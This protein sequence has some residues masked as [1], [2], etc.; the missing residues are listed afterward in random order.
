MTS[1]LVRARPIMYQF[2]IRQV[3]HYD[4]R[5]ARQ[6]AR[7][8][9]RLSCHAVR[10]IP[11]IAS[12]PPI[13]VSVMGLNFPNP[14]GLAAGFDKNGSLTGSLGPAGFGFVEIG[15]ITPDRPTKRN[16]GIA[17]MISNLKRTRSRRLSGPGQLLGVNVGSVRTTFSEELIDD[18]ISAMEVVWDQADYLTI[19]LSSPHGWAHAAGVSELEVQ[20]LLERIKDRHD[21][22][23]ARSGQRLPIT[24]KVAVTGDPIHPAVHIARD[25]GFDALTV[26]T[27]RADPSNLVCSQI[28]ELA[29]TLSPT[30]LIS[31]GGITSVD[32]AWRRLEAGAALVQLYTG[33][34]EQGPFLARRIV[35]DLHARYARQRR[36]ISS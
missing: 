28:R 2:L 9:V 24:V 16:D 31:V 30:A 36:D 33:L 27:R 25:L 22:L 23:S 4:S 11:F 5:T 21:S 15:T 6:F 19:N 32:S 3:F 18:F 35:R 1:I 26:E 10:M 12:P 14:V 29:A 8:A 20:T 17:V 7:T 13:P 34:V